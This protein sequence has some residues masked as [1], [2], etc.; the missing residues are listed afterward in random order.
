MQP[1]TFKE[2]FVNCFYCK[3]IVLKGEQ[4]ENKT[5]NFTKLQNLKYGENPHQEASLY[6]F[7]NEIDWELLS[8]GVLSY[9]NIL[10]MTTSLEIASEFFD[11]AATVIVKHANPCAVALAN[12]LQQAWAKA[13][14]S[15]IIGIFNSVAAFTRGIDLTF[16]KQLAEMNLGIIVAPKFSAE[17]VE[18]LKKVKN[19]KVVQINTPLKDVLKFVEEDIRLTPFGALIQQKDV[20]DFD[21]NTFKVM[22]KTKPEQKMLEDMIFAFKVVKHAKSNAIVTAKDL[23]TIGISTGQTTRVGSVEIALAKICDSAKDAVIAS[24]GAISTVDNIQIAAQNRISAII[25]PMGTPKDAEIIKAADKFNIS[26]VS[27]GIRHFKH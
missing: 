13:I 18:E 23:R 24:D 21:V 9:N 14:D 20:K 11:V 17:A 27:T 12:D 7:N 5:Y 25:Q 16:A 26:M 22:T 6:G 15:D 10:D 2:F 1:D 8:G 19:L 4:M 3:I